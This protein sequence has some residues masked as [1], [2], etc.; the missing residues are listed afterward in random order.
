MREQHDTQL[1]E[2]VIRANA[3][4]LEAPA[5]ELRAASDRRNQEVS[6]QAHSDVAAADSSASTALIRAQA[7]RAVMVLLAMSVLAIAIG[8][9]I[10]LVLGAETER[11]AQ[12]PA[13]AIE[14]PAPAAIWPNMPPPA[15][16]DEDGSIV[17]TNFSLFRTKEMQLGNRELE[18]EAGHHFDKGTDTQF[19]HAWCYTDIRENGVIINVVLGHKK[20]DQ[21]PE[22]RLPTSQELD[23]TGLS[24]NDHL[25]L[26][27][28]CPWLDGNPDLAASSLSAPA[29]SNSYH[30]TGD[31]TAA[32]VDKM[33][34]ALKNGARSVAFDSPGG[35]I[36]EAMR[37][38][39]ELRNAGVTTVV[40]GECASACSILF[41]GGTERD[42]QPMARLGVHQ[43]SSVSHP[44]HE[45]EAQLL[46]GMLVAL[47]KEAG[48]S[49]EFFVAGAS[50][51]ASDMY[52]LTRSELRDWGVTT[53]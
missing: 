6:A 32:S 14:T 41:L 15:A 36:N 8:F 39:A 5:K 26:F 53:S 17:T 49:E 44:T 46:S 16:R 19:K 11:Q 50:T 20:P 29:V 42:I 18:V 21:F 30:F 13:P 48:V 38:Y 23:K 4:R 40:S 31:V 24:L 35:L 12:L 33:I 22:R 28:A 37:G 27:N 25:E 10:W 43:W 1:L 45:S 7:Y 34:A 3:Q 2:Q 47:F 51:G 9:A 52:W